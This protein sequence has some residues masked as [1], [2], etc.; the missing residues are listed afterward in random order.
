MA[1]SMLKIEKQMRSL[2]GVV[3][4][5]RYAMAACQPGFGLDHT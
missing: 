2:I 4:R 5:E 3:R 1:M